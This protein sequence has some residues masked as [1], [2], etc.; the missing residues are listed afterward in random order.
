MPA[1]DAMGFFCEVRDMLDGKPG[2]KIEGSEACD[3]WG[4]CTRLVG[5]S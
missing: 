5:G 2:L 4:H 3:D 1:Q